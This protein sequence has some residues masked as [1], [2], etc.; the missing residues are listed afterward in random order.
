MAAR[1]TTPKA[2]KMAREAERDYSHRL[3]IDKLGVKPGQ[4]VAVLG[5]EGAEFLKDLAERV[6][7]YAR[8]ELIP[9]ADQVF[10]SVES[11]A[12]LAKLKPIVRSMRRHCAIWIVYPK[13]QTH[14]REGDVI[15]SGK[16]AGLVDNKVCKFSETH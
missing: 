13:G 6:P 10:F 14:I 11:R 1:G 12:D 9:A 16:A 2:K 4:T 5:V 15:A 7:D 3:L 8:G